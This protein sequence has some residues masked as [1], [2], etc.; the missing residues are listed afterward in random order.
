MPVLFRLIVQVLASFGV[1]IYTNLY[2][3]NFGDLLGLGDIDLGIFSIPATID[4]ATILDEIKDTLE[5][6]NSAIG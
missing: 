6:I 4:D 3:S 5:K 2:V 1:I